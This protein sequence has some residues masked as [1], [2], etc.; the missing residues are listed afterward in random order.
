MRHPDRPRQDLGQLSETAR[1]GGI[2]AAQPPSPSHSA[3][4][5]QS[6]SQH[7]IDYTIMG[8]TCAT[9]RHRVYV[10]V[11]DDCTSG[12]DNQDDVSGLCKRMPSDCRVVQ[13]PRHT[14]HMNHHIA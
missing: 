6:R 10:V 12:P 5:L 7:T 3:F 9:R 2:K 1:G 11:E 8:F 13:H 14:E 4:A